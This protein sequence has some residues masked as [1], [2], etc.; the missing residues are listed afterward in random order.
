MF[1]KKKPLKF[2]PPLIWFVYFSAVTK[3]CYHFIKN[4]CFWQM[5]SIS[6]FFSDIQKPNWIFDSQNYAMSRYVFQISWT[7]TI[8]TAGTGLCTGCS[9]RPGSTC[10]TRPVMT[11]CVFKSPWCSPVSTFC[12]TWEVPA[13]ALSRC[14]HPPTTV[15]FSFYKV[16]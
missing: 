1:L 12:H 14:S 15:S 8:C 3:T 7:T 2:Y 16:F 13:L 10:F 4:Y 11:R 9:A 6:C 5:C